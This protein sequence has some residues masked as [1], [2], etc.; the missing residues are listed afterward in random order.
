L[1]GA[2]IEI[3]ANNRAKTHTISNTEARELTTTFFNKWFGTMDERLRS[4]ARAANTYSSQGTRTSASR[5]RGLPKSLK[6]LCK[7]YFEC[8]DMALANSETYRSIR[9][10]IRVAQFTEAWRMVRRHVMAKDDEGTAIIK[11]LGIRIAGPGRGQSYHSLLKR[12]L[13]TNYEMKPATFESYIRNA[14]IPLAMVDRFGWGL[15]LFLP[16]NCSG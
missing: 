15:L 1:C 9:Y 5:V 8:S 11:A 7:A 12:V 10:N 13:C 2:E 14:Q 3:T 4:L 6:R 16:N